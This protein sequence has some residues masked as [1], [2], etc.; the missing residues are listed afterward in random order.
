MTLCGTLRQGTTPTLCGVTLLGT[1]PG[2]AALASCPEI[3]GGMI[4]TGANMVYLIRK[5]GTFTPLY[6]T[7]VVGFTQYPF[8]NGGPIMG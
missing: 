3:S 1:F 5:P 6:F 8:S 2:V 7:K 4:I